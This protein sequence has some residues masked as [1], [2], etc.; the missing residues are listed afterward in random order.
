MALIRRSPPQDD[1]DKKD[2]DPIPNLEEK[3]YEARL[4]MVADLGM[5]LQ[6]YNGEEKPSR[7]EIALGLEIVG[8]TIL[9]DEK[10]VPRLLW[11]KPFKIF[12]KLTKKGHELK[13]YSIFDSDAKV[14]QVPDWDAQLGKCCSVRVVHTQ[15]KGDNAGFTYDNV[16]LL[17]PIP[18]KYRDGV[19]PASMELAIGDAD[20]EDNV[21]TK[22]LFGLTR[23]VYDK[24]IQNQQDTSAS[25]VDLSYDDDIPF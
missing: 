11:S 8:E 18:E 17:L 19:P 5:Q 20:N 22:A 15:G 14:N 21:V 13:F 9:I 12:H 1:S 2:F 7:Q 3:E 25:D 10:E 16:G 6:E 23:F 24:R 4:V